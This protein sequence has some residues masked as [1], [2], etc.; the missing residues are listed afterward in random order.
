MSVVAFVC[1]PV[2]IA[3]CANLVTHAKEFTV[4]SPKCWNFH[5]EILGFRSEMDWWCKFGKLFL[6]D[7]CCSSVLLTMTELTDAQCS[8]ITHSRYIAHRACEPMPFCFWHTLELCY[9]V[10]ITYSP[11][12]LTSKH[13][14][15]HMANLTVAEN[16]KQIY[17]FSRPI[18]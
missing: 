8:A 2:H 14:Q 4:C 11:T 13:M 7:F 15:L 3:L 12:L 9:H 10:R 6:R 1:L 18:I 5:V 17:K 16:T